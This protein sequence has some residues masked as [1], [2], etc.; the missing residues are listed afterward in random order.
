MKY[1]VYV[2]PGYIRYFETLADAQEFA[3]EYDAEVKEI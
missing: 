2:K 1:Y 3:K